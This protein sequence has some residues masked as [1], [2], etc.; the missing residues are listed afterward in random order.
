[1]GGR[2][3]R[4]DRE[5]FVLI[6]SSGLLLDRLPRLTDRLMGEL[7]AHSAEFDRAVPRE[8]HWFQINEALRYG[9]EAI[10][11]SRTAPRRDLEYAE[12]IGRRRAEQ[13]LPLELLHHAYRQA[14]YLVWDELLT[15]V[16]E[17]DPEALTVLARTAGQIWAG[18]DRQ[19]AA[20]TDAYRATE[21]ELHRRTDER[22]QALLD[23]LL[24]GR[25][26]P[27]LA[28]RAAAGLDLPERGRYAVVVLKVE[29]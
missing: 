14:G 20:V 16:A 25:V 8:E 26:T 28:A 29:R 18:V 19:T 22:A 7:L 12:E 4:T 21:R 13:G 24:E 15:I 2:R 6:R 9:I 10:A 3:A 27:G 11:A 17:E 23:A 5:W 1:M